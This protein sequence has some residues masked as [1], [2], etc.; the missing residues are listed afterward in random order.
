MYASST[1]NVRTR[2]MFTRSA[3]AGA[4]RP[5]RKCASRGSGAPASHALT[6]GISP[7]AASAARTPASTGGEGAVVIVLGAALGPPMDRQSRCRRYERVRDR[8]R[9]HEHVH[10]AARLSRGRELRG[11]DAIPGLH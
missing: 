6:V 2:H 10:G 7:G 4:T 3:N 8:V 11:D 1:V 9:A 5:T